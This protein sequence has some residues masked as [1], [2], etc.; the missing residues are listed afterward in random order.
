MVNGPIHE[1]ESDAGTESGHDHGPGLSDMDASAGAASRRETQ[2]E[3]ADAVP[4]L[5]RLARQKPVA[6]SA[7]QWTAFSRGLNERLNLEPTS[8]KRKCARSLRDCLKST[9]S[10]ALRAGAAAA[11]TAVLA[12]LLAALIWLAA[13]FAPAPAPAAAS[14]LPHTAVPCVVAA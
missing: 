14:L 8:S 12:A 1:W 2:R 9:D 5:K 3:L 11:A 10:K 13:H 7:A 6:P 4:A